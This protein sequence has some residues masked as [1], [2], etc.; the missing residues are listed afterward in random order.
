M[1]SLLQAF[2][3]IFASPLVIAD[4]K[5]SQI[6]TILQD[7][8]VITHVDVGTAGASH[9]DLMAFEAPFETES[10]EKGIMSGFL[11]TVDIPVGQGEYFHDRVAQI[12]FEFGG[13][14]TIAVGGKSVYPDGRAEMQA[15]VQQVRPV[16]GGTGRF[17]GARG[18]IATTRRDQGHYEHII[19]L[20][21]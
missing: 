20:V 6:I 16:I 14:D 2:L 5:V 12:V 13:V 19:T 9:G 1:R 7:V 18:E 3:L 8:P 17:I 4:A 10:G 21:D 15:H 11:L